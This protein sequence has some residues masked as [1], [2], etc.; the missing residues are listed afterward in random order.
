LFWLIV[1][2]LG[3]FTAGYIAGLCSSVY[4][5]DHLKDLKRQEEF[6]QAAKEEEARIYKEAEEE[7]ERRQELICASIHLNNNCRLCGGQ[8]KDD[9]TSTERDSLTVYKLWLTGEV[10]L[11]AIGK[12]PNSAGIRVLQA[13]VISRQYDPPK[14]AITWAAQQLNAEILPAHKIREHLLVAVLNEAVRL[15]EL[16]RESEPEPELDPRMR[17]EKEG[18]V[19]E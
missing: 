9:M 2:S 16:S 8:H 6:K 7:R 14:E 15:K 4:Y 19:K 12:F 13:Y 18:R 3:T 17:E 5:F 10:D 1:V 11:P